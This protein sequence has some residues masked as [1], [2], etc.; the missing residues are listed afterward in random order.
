MNKRHTL[1][2]GL[3]C[4]LAFSY[5]ALLTAGVAAPGMAG[6]LASVFVSTTPQQVW[7]TISARLVDSGATI[8][9]NTNT[10]FHL[11]YS[12]KPIDREVLLGHKGTTV[13]Y[14]GYCYPEPGDPQN[15][16]QTRGL[17]GKFFLSEAERYW[18]AQQE[19][20]N[21]PVYSIFNPPRPR[22]I[23]SLGY[24]ASKPALVRHQ[25]DTFRPGMTCFILSQQPLPI[26]TDRDGDGLNI[27]Q[28]HDIG[29]D[30][31]NPDTDGDG[32]P[33]GLE[34]L[35]GTN[36]LN[37]DTDGDGIIDGIEDKNH[38]GKV[39]PG[40]T[41]PRKKDTDGD[42]LCDGYCRVNNDK[43]ICN[44]YLGTDCVDLPYG[45][46]EGEDK[47]LNGTVDSG[48]TDP[49]KWSTGGD[50]VSDE[51]RLYECYLK[52]SSGC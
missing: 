2:S 30:P 21:K 15:L 37:R 4:A 18:R 32:L 10:I 23:A 3:F 6:G 27:K 31:N 29:T 43:R 38:N 46:W 52:G 34:F 35:T 20:A 44:D 7:A 41:D 28:E 39:D 16:R 25:L 36:P 11:P 19:L 51:E 50:G 17:P 12:M 33:D 45:R 24:A 40:E 47:N 42:G 5:A 49:T 26:G 8:P 14:W 9:A 1:L 48:E 13:R 22:D